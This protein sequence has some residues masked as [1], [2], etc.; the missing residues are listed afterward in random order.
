[1][2]AVSCKSE[3]VLEFMK[4]VECG[5]CALE[6]GSDSTVSC[7]TCGA[8]FPAVEGTPVLLRRDNELFRAEEV[9]TKAASGFSTGVQNRVRAFLPSVTW[10]SPDAKTAPERCFP[11]MSGRRQRCL[12]IGG[13]DDATHH[14]YLRHY[15]EEVVITDI[16]VNPGVQYVCDGH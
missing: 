10:L 7:G 3:R 14:E 1:A 6:E 2:R 13:G 4:C 12:V 11:A 16:V 15:F 9:F 8:I 5:G